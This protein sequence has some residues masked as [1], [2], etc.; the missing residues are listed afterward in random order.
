[1]SD[2]QHWWHDVSFPGTVIPWLVERI[3]WQVPGNG[4]ESVTGS[5]D[6]NKQMHR[7][8]QHALE[9]GYG[10]VKLFGNITDQRYCREYVKKFVDEGLADLGGHV[11]DKSSM[12]AQV[13]GVFHSSLRERYGLVEAECRLAGIP[14]YGPSNQ[15]L[16]L[17]ESSILDRWRSILG[18][19]LGGA[20]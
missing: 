14:F 7:S 5:I 10:K 16:I 18:S 6:R 19:P 1:M 11:D 9:K 20:Q 12:Y 13:Y 3:H 17:E 2:R 8:I 15:Q 4:V